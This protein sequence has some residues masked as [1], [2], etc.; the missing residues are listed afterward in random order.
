MYNH[1]YAGYNAQVL[2]AAIRSHILAQYGQQRVVE[3]AMGTSGNVIVHTSINHHGFDCATCMNSLALSDM[4]DII[5]GVLQALKALVAE[6]SDRTCFVLSTRSISVLPRSLL[7]NVILTRCR[8]DNMLNYEFGKF[9]EK[10]DE[11][12]K[13]CINGLPDMVDVRQFAYACIGFNIPYN[14]FAKAVLRSIQDSEHVHQ[15]VRILSENDVLVQRIKK[16]VMVWEKTF[17]DIHLAF[18][19]AK[20]T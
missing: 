10:V 8:S 6:Y 7:F 2:Y 3:H 14:I 11:L 17:V 20:H 15:V 16:D 13:T 1:L 5:Q 9:G 19:P 4:M 18:N 12:L